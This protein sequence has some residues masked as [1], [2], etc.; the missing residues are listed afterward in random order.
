MADN[1]PRVLGAIL[2]EQFELLDLYGPL[3]MFGC[4]GPEL[5]IVTVAERSVPVASTPGV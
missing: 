4:I 5:E 1:A 2:Y 3:E